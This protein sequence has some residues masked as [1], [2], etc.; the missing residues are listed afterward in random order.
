VIAPAKVEVRYDVCEFDDDRVF[1]VRAGSRDTAYALVIVE[2]ETYT[3]HNNP[4]VIA[5]IT[6]EPHVWSLPRLTGWH[7]A[8]LAGPTDMNQVT[9]QTVAAILEHVAERW[10]Q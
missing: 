9:A 2:L 8:Y 4:W 6:P 3:I 5:M 1:V 7:P 10:Q